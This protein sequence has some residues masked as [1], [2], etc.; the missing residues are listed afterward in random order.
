MNYN[1][2]FRYIVDEGNDIVY[3]SDVETYE[4]Y[5]LN[6]SVL[7]VLG[8]PSREEW[9]GKPCYKVLQNLDQP[10]S[11]CTNHLLTEGC[12]YIWEHQNLNLKRKFLLR[13]RLVSLNGRVVR[14]EIANDITKQ[15][16]DAAQLRKRI[17]LEETLMACVQTLRQKQNIS[18]AIQ[19][20]LQLIGAYYKADRAY[21]FEVDREQET[22][23]N[24]YEWCET[25]VIP[26][27]RKLQ[28]LPLE[29]ADRWF[30]QFKRAEEFYITSLEENVDH[31]TKEYEILEMQDIESLM[32]APLMLEDKIVGFLGVDNPADNTDSMRLLRS[33]ASLIINDLHQ[34]K[35]AND[36]EKKSRVDELTG[37]G[38]HRSYMEMLQTLEW[39]SPQT[40]G[41]LFLDINGLKLANDVHGHQYGDYLVTHTAEV[42]QNTFRSLVYRIGGD[43]F[44]ILCVNMPKEIFD[45]KVET[46]REISRTDDEFRVSLGAC[47]SEKGRN[48]LWQVER[49]DQLMNV[50][51]QA[52]YGG[53]VDFGGN[54]RARLSRALLQE[55]RN[56]AFAV[57]LQPKIELKTGRL[58]GAEALVR[59]F[60]REGMLIFPD[61]FISK[62]EAEGIIR[63]VDFFVWEEVCKRLKAWREEGKQALTISVNLSRITLQEHEIAK[64]LLSVCKQYGIGPELIDVEVTERI[65]VLDKEKLQNLMKSLR[66]AGFSVFLDDFGAE[67]SNLSILTMTDFDEIKIDKSLIVDI[68]GN[69][70]SRVVTAHIINICK[71]L[72]H[73][74][75]VAEGIETQGQSE[76]LQE[77]GCEVGQGY[78]FDRPLPIKQFVEKYLE[79]NPAI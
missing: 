74:R 27:I 35:M 7:S 45:R 61:E 60:D 15:E 52:Y 9:L 5:Y 21:I 30:E 23:S 36:L 39:N 55:I 68:E 46:L 53:R 32:A 13:D 70:K 77:Y 44:V 51:K 58:V 10:C 1:E 71:E 16:E 11:F 29:L 73:A 56:G 41:V 3:L 37:L 63:H 26:Q 54:Y 24:T 75:S 72:N 6:R 59:K 20:I 67:Y 66:E 19:E 76:L 14:L 31:T 17:H 2:I 34:Q 49:A 38:N 4:L 50:D 33:A 8:N 22:F 65:G 48:I 43:E 40:L 64:K 42:L 25:G 78:F 79:G 57:Y 62:Y 12:F 47:W 28:D 18:E 69:Q